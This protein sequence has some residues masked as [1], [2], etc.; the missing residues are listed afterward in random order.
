MNVRK[1]GAV[2]IAASLVTTTS[3]AAIVGYFDAIQ[4]GMVD[5]A[6]GWICENLSPTTTP[7]GNIVITIDGPYGVGTVAMDEPVANIWG[8]TRTDVPQAG[9]CIGNN[10]TGWSAGGMWLAN[11]PTIHA[12]Y[13]YGAMLQELGGSGKNCSGQYPVCY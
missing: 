7:P 11:H 5:S 6:S 13:K 4:I 8:G 10:N 12:Y 2:A 3:H 1:L 9:Y